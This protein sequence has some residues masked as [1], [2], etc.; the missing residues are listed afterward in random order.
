MSMQTSA[1]SNAIPDAECRPLAAERRSLRLPVTTRDGPI[2]LAVDSQP[3]RDAERAIV[4]VDARA[5][6]KLCL[7]SDGVED[8]AGR[9]RFGGVVTGSGDFVDAALRAGLSVPI[10]VIRTLENVKEGRVQFLRRH[11]R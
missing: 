10:P 2:F 6:L 4:E 9:D 11:H 7:A 8:T 5:L 3:E 1:R